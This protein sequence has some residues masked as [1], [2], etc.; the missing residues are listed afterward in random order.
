MPLERPQLLDAH[1]SD[2]PV[3]E[4]VVVRPIVPVNGKMHHLVCG[5]QPLTVKV[6][7]PDPVGLRIVILTK[8]RAWATTISE[9][10]LSVANVCSL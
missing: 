7:R 1:G 4:R 10:A 3:E 9:G 5:T 8:R 2:G 6:R